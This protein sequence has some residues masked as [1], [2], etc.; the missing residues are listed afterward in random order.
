[1]WRM[2]GSVLATAVWCIDLDGL[3][4][5]SVAILVVAKKRD[6]IARGVICIVLEEMMVSPKTIRSALTTMKVDKTCT[7]LP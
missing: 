2:I 5:R 6:L 1:M 4:D 7:Y 3:V